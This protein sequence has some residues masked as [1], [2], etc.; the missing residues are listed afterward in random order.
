MKKVLGILLVALMM[1]MSFAE[2][3]TESKEIQAQR[4]EVKKFVEDAAAYYNK[5]GEAKAFAEFQKKDGKFFKGD[6]YIFLFEGTT[7]KVQPVTPKLVGKDL[8]NMKDPNGKL[9]IQE[10][11][12]VTKENKTGWVEYYWPEPKT[13]KLK[14]KISYLIQLDAKK[15]TYLGAGVY[16]KD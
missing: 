2:T 11:V 12:K 13:E 5:E 14:A 15:G 9:F 16:K 7:C 6:L 1:G 4:A 3:W 8:G 10:F